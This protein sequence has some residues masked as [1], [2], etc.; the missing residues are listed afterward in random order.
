MLVG[1]VASASAQGLTDQRKKVHQDIVQVKQNVSNSTK[2]AQNAV[3]KLAD[4]QKQLDDAQTKLTQLTSQLAGAQK[5]K[6]QADAALATAQQELQAASAAVTQAN[7]AVSQQ[8]VVIGEAGRTQYQQESSLVQF[9]AI[10]ASQTSQDLAE[11]IQW[12]TT[13]FDAVSAQ[14]DRLKQLQATAD[15]A[16]KAMAKAE[17]QVQAR[18]D[19]AA[20]QLVSVQTLTDQAARQET[21]ITSLVAANK[22]ASAAAQAQLSVNKKQYATLVAKQA[23]LDAQIKKAAEQAAHKSATKHTIDVITKAYT[24][25]RLAAQLLANPNITFTGGGY[26]GLADIEH[27]ASDGHPLACA[28][29]SPYAGQAPYIENSDLMAM[30][31]SM[32]QKYRIQLGVVTGYHHCDGAGPGLHQGADAIDLNGASALGGGATGFHYVSQADDAFIAQFVRDLNATA[33]QMGIRL[34]VTQVASSG[35]SCLTVPGLNAIRGGSDS[36][37]HL[38][39]G[40]MASPER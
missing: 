5:A 31:V 36:C 17:T 26:D 1:P 37:N 4:S 19:A 16:Q 8:L 35:A 39:M 14:L 33:N 32:T 12:S 7:N 27:I 40:V 20:A 15:A 29:Y 2:A 34:M 21:Q 9:G 11:R 22:K 28:T 24:P 25:E 10:V 30:L 13:I 6:T 38:H 3:T 18:R 23:S